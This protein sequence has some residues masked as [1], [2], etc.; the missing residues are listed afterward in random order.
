VRKRRKEDCEGD[1]YREEERGLEQYCVPHYRAV[2]RGTGTAVAIKVAMRV[3]MELS[4][5]ILIEIIAFTIVAI[6]MLTAIAASRPL[7]HC[8]PI[9]HLPQRLVHKYN[10][11]LSTLSPP[12]PSSLHPSRLVV[13]I[14]PKGDNNWLD[15]VDIEDVKLPEG[16]TRKSYIGLTA[17]TGQLSGVCRAVGRE[18]GAFVRQWRKA[19]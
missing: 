7:E 16:W 9:I 17:S 11:P 15:C 5:A 19:A 12:L 14:D 13:Q 8:H 4:M 18:R 6:T 1:R 10:S 3:L 2:W